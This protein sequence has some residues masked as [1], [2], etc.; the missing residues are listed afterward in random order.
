M[1]PLN[2]SKRILC[3]LLVLLCILSGCTTET[4]SVADENLTI[5]F[6]DVGQGDCTFIEFPDGRTMLIDTGEKE[7]ANTVISYIQSRDKNKI[8]YL[9]SSHPHT[10]HMG[11]M[12]K[13]IETFDIG[14]IYMPHADASTSIYEKLL[15]TILEKELFVTTVCAGD[16]IISEDG[17]SAKVVAPVYE[18]QD[19]NDSSIVLRLV[20]GKTAFLFTGDIENQSERDITADIS[21]DVVKVPHHGSSTSSSKSFVSRVG[22]DYAVFSLGKDNIYGHPH[23]GIEERWASSGAE[24]LR[25][26]KLGNIV[27][28]S[29]GENITYT[30]HNSIPDVTCYTW[31]LNTSSKKIHYPDCASVS[32]TKEDNKAYSSDSLSV[33]TAKGYTACGLCKPKE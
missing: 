8:D 3:L 30:T 1:I 21:A 25:T 13:I 12:Q 18:Y 15:E 11:G 2:Y 27:F 24:I 31:V 19:L 9:I 26:D 33:L 32:D 4:Y 20:F 5:S 28:V 6:I 7:F 29:D 22:A 10:D 14:S 16:T 17:I 23:D